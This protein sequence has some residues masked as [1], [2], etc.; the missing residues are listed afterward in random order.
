MNKVFQMNQAHFDFHLSLLT[1]ML[2]VIET[3]S[4]TKDCSFGLRRLVI[5]LQG[6]GELNMTL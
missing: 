3:L 2:L 6:S 5:G 4:Q 1:A